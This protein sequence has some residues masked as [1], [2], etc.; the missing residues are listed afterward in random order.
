MGYH[1]VA[2]TITWIAQVICV[3]IAVYNYPLSSKDD[4][5]FRRCLL[6]FVLALGFMLVRTPH[7]TYWHFNEMKAE[8]E[9][10]CTAN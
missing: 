5:R 7:K 8:Q 6:H 1:E 2:D 10:A 4:E 3:L 9:T